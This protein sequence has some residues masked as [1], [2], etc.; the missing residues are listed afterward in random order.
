M[1]LPKYHHAK[2]GRRIKYMRKRSGGG[3]LSKRDDYEQK[4]QLASELSL[5]WGFL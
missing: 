5:I 3:L 4:D 2:Y 1:A